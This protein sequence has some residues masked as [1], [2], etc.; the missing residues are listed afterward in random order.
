MG[1]FS[2][3]PTNQIYSVLNDD[4]AKL[5]VIVSR[6][7]ET[8]GWRC[9]TDVDKIEQR[10]VCQE[11]VDSL[12]AETVAHFTREEGLM[13]RYEYPLTRVHAADHMVL[14]RTIENFQL[15][16]RNGTTSI[17]TETVAYIKD[18]LTSH[19]RVADHH[20]EN[21]LVGCKDKRTVKRKDLSTKG[22]HPLSF[23]FAIFDKV[24]NSVIIANRQRRGEYEAKTFER[25]VT[26]YIEHD[27]KVSDEEQRRMQR[28]VWYD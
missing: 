7:K 24:S 9:K 4:H 23:L 8:S 3:A 22:S 25:K 19:I 6:L 28:N 14:L 21:F 1:M 11:L 10:K 13:K 18:W 5:Y 26:H 16:L 27:T 17:T 12:V 15:Q 2:R 20:L